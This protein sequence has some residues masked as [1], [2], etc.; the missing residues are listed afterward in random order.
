MAAPTRIIEFAPDDLP[1]ATSPTWVDITQYV[2][3]RA[4]VRTVRGRPDELSVFSTGSMRL[5]LQNTDRRFDPSYASGPYFGKLRPGKQ[6]RVRAVV[7][8]TSYDIFTGFVKGW[9]Q[10]FEYTVDSTVDIECTD[11][12]GWMQRSPL[13]TDLI[14]DQ[15]AVVSGLG[16]ALRSTD[17]Y[18]W[19]DS[20][21][22]NDAQLVF[23]R[24]DQVGSMATG[25]ASPAIRFDGSTLWQ[26][27]TAISTFF[28]GAISFWL[29]TSQKPDLSGTYSGTEIGI[30]GNATKSVPGPAFHGVQVNIN[31]EGQLVWRYDNAIT[32]NSK[33]TRAA[34]NDGRPHHVVLVCDAAGTAT[35]YLDGLPAA[36]ASTSGIPALGAHAI[37]NAAMQFT[38]YYPGNQF[39]NGSLQDFAVWTSA[40]TADQVSAL[41]GISSGFVEEPIADR[42]DRVLDAA[43]LPA[44]RRDI[45]STLRAVCGRL[46]LGG[47]KCLD[48]MQELERTEQ[49]RMFATKSGNLAFLSRY[50]LWEDTRGKT[51]QATFSDDGAPGAIAYRTFGF[52]YGDDLDVVND[53][54]V[55]AAPK[56]RGRA[57]DTTSVSEVG[58]RGESI[59]TVLTSEQYAAAMAGVL[60][61]QRKTEG[62]Y[63]TLPIV[64]NPEVGNVWETCLG[65]ELGDRIQVEKTPSG[66]GSQVQLQVSIERIE[67]N[68]TADDGWELTINGAPIPTTGIFIVG[69]SLVGGPDIVGF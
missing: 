36:L 17:D 44:G 20:V 25:S 4:R 33:I 24:R 37:G 66:V 2:R 45:S 68:I 26:L 69:S 14:D 16:P 55:L 43:G 61:T 64:V 31:E 21:G 34:V 27:S 18:L 1:L 48:G 11:L 46:V 49:G 5:T 10:D 30:F 8:A 54:T 23:G 50:W 62:V 53:I 39:F 65:L 41:Y 67:W 9:P 22:S 60:V 29:Q 6:I 38:E 35:I 57:I 12:L 42:I 59:D 15:L 3:D 58:R 51:V 28:V 40:P 52:R 63:R 56:G 7:G 47:R 32:S 13:P 19:L